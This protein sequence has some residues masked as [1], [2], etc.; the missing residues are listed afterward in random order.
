MKKLSWKLF[1]DYSAERAREFWGTEKAEP[2]IELTLIA[3]KKRMDEERKTEL[4]DRQK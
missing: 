3:A 4:K 2:W 1:E